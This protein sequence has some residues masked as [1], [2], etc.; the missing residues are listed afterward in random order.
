MTTHFQRLTTSTLSNLVFFVDL[1]QQTHPIPGFTGLALLCNLDGSSCKLISNS[2]Q[3]RNAP[4]S[5]LEFYNG[6]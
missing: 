5:P 2:Q 4:N 1:G 3:L 6:V